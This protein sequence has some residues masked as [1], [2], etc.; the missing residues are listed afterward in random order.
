MRNELKRRKKKLTQSVDDSIIQQIR[1]M[2]VEYGKSQITF[3]E[4]LNFVV[5]TFRNKG[6]ESLDDHWKPISYFCDLCAIKYDIIAKFET[7]KE[8]SDAI[9]NYVQRNNPNHN[10]TFPDDDPYTTF[11]RCNEAFKIVPLHVRRSLYELFKEDYL[12]FDYEY[13]GD[14]EYNIC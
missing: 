4:F 7:L 5:Y 11:D 13:R 3:L 8:D 2:N 10:V 12:L 6:I 9:L 1:R 14:D